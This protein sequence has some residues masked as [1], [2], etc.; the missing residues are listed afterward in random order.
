[1]SNASNNSSILNPL[2]TV[3]MCTTVFLLIA[4]TIFGNVLVVIAIHTSRCLKTPQNLFLVSL[5]IADIFIAVLLM[6]FTLINDLTEQ[7]LI[8]GFLCK[9]FLVLDVFFCTSSILHLCVIGLDRYWSVTQV[10]KYFSK[11]TSRRTKR[12]ILVAWLLS[13]LITLPHFAE[14]RLDPPEDGTD[15]ESCKPS[16]RKWYVAFSTTCSFFVPCIIL[17]LVYIRIYQIATDKIRPGL[18]NECINMANKTINKPKRSPKHMGSFQQKTNLSRHHTST[19]GEEFQGSSEASRDDTSL[20]GASFTKDNANGQST[21]TLDSSCLDN[22]KLFLDATDRHLRGGA[23]AY[24]RAASL[25]NIPCSLSPLQLNFKE[26]QY[27]CSDDFLSFEETDTCGSQDLKAI[28]LQMSPKPAKRPQGVFLKSRHTRSSLELNARMNKNTRLTLVI[29]VVTGVFIVCW[30]P[31]FITY[32]LKV[33]VESFQVSDWL[34]QFFTWV[35]YFNS[36]LNPIVYSIFNDNFRKTFI[37]ILSKNAMC[38]QNRRCA[39]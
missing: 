1:M 24:K 13:A 39:C 27:H 21:E 17:I 3:A 18:N 19:E 33:L 5:A 9:L 29:S 20:Q 30:L 4:F 28:Y 7:K 34:F 38:K 14:Y 35:G 37:K 15:T 32:N 10:V 31:F 22:T 16:S 8:T 26:K 23:I 11:R 6:P 25:E 2:A 12:L 36:C